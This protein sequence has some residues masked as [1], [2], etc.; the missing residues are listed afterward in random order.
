MRSAYWQNMGSSVPLGTHYGKIALGKRG[1][2][3]FLSGA[4][5]S[6]ANMKWIL[7]LVIAATLT[8]GVKAT[9]KSQFLY[10]A[11]NAGTLYQYR[12]GTEGTLHPLNP[13]SFK[14]SSGAV[15]LALHP[16]GRFLYAVT[17]HK[18]NS[19]HDLA[20]VFTYRIRP[21]GTLAPL[22]SHPRTLSA[23][24]DNAVMDPKGRFL[25]VSGEDDHL[26]TFRIQHDGALVPLPDNKAV[27]TFHIDTQ[28][29][30]GGEVT[31]TYNYATLTL[32]PTGHFLYSYSVQDGFDSISYQ[33]YSFRLDAH[34]IFHSLQPAG[35]NSE[36]GTGSVGPCFFTPSGDLLVVHDD[37]DKI[38][39][40]V[41]HIGSQ[42]QLIPART[43]FLLHNFGGDC[44]KGFRGADSLDL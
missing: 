36:G 9:P 35:G 14:V 27:S 8:G 18:P 19:G 24:A 42:G 28:G 20:Q 15:T 22:G 32:D 25:F 43:P 13:P 4:Y 2:K 21:N 29:D 6:E 17:V 39:T 16:S 26:F 40:N 34:G 5:E 12:I 10:A 38:G 23:P 1:V 30:G 11:T 31:E 33:F 7:I 41:F 37:G 44:D 3:R